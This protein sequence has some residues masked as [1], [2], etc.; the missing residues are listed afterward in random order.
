MR[1][2][3]EQI[4]AWLVEL[5]QLLGPFGAD[6]AF[7]RALL[8]VEWL[9]GELAAGR[10]ELPVPSTGDLYLPYALTEGLLD[11]VPEVV[12]AATRVVEALLD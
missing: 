6:P 10:L 9:Q 7:E 4:E 8:E 12:D 11:D 3:K 1:A 2:T 5:G